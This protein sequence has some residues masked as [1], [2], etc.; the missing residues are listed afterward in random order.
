MFLANL[1][2]YTDV[3]AYV[4]SFDTGVAPAV[5]YGVTFTPETVSDSV[6]LT[7][8]NTLE[9]QTLAAC[10]LVARGRVSGRLRSWLFSNA[11]Q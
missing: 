9:G 5:G 8:L 3:K 11:Q 1:Q 7:D 4:L 6:R 10:D 2:E